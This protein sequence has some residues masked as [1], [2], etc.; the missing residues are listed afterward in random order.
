MKLSQLIVPI[1]LVAAA[2]PSHAEPN[3]VIR[4]SGFSLSADDGT[5]WSLLL[6]THGNRTLRWD[7]RNGHSCIFRQLGPE[8]DI[9][10]PFGKGRATV[11][12]TGPHF[13]LQHDAPGCKNLST[14]CYMSPSPAADRGAVGFLMGFSKSMFPAPA[15]FPEITD[16]LTERAA[17]GGTALEQSCAEILKDHWAET[18]HQFGLAPPADLVHLMDRFEGAS[19]R[20]ETVPATDLEVA[21]APVP[22]SRRSLGPLDVNAIGGSPDRPKPAATKGGIKPATAVKSPEP[23]AAAAKPAR[24]ER[25]ARRVTDENSAPR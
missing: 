5:R 7:F 4:P 2:L 12:N 14:F 3:L 17:A 18:C 6:S 23:A 8:M 11:V 16:L 25:K 22:P 9:E 15:S 19:L 24:E 1:A 21:P 10:S 13:E 20:P